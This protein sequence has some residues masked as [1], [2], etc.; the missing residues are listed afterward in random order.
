M[1]I[2]ATPHPGLIIRMRLAETG[3]INVESVPDIDPS[4]INNVVA[5][6][7]FTFVTR[8]ID[9][10]QVRP[11]HVGIIGRSIVVHC[12]I[13][14]FAHVCKGGTGYLGINVPVPR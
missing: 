6:P 9:I 13:V 3:D 12:A 1:V 10:Q 4:R 2:L 5:V 11:L 8:G 7:S 14:V